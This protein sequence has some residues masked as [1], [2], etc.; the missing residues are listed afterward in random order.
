V[1]LAGDL[2]EAEQLAVEGEELGAAEDFVNYAIGRG[3]RARVASDRGAHGDAE[4][5]ARDA[6]E[7]A[8][9]TDFSWVHADVHTALAYVLAAS[10]RIEEARAELETAL[11]RH[12][13]HGNAFEAERTRQLLVE[14]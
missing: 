9:K 6:L 1:Y 11:D 4:S 3:I 12:L 7:Y 14:L 13:S 5:L 10:D 8:Y 2:E